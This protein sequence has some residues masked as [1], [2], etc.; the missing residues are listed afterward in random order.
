MKKTINNSDGSTD[1]VTVIT[2]THVDVNKTLILSAL[3]KIMD[4]YIE[5]RQDSLDSD[6][7]KA[8]S[9]EFK[10]YMKQIIKFE[11]MHYDSNQRIYDYGAT[12]DSDSEV[13]N[14][15]QLLLANEEVEEVRQLIL[16]NINKLLHRGDKINL[17]VDQTDRLTTS[18]SVFQKRAQ[19]IKKKMWLSKTKFWILVGAGAIFVLY[20]LI[21]VECGLPF[22]SSCLR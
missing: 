11:E 2:I 13:I 18:S 12:N 5:F 1:L 16:D 19:S 22:Y 20:I 4:K 17:L 8:K 6:P 14:P 15:N 21:G 7:Q 9:G 10:L 3:K